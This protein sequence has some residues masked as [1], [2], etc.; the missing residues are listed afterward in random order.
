MATLKIYTISFLA[1]WG[2]AC[3]HAQPPSYSCKVEIE[4]KAKTKIKFPAGD[5]LFISFDDG[6]QNDTITI[7]AKYKN[8]I[9]GNLNA[10]NL[11][12]FAGIMKIPKNELKYPIR[13]FFDGQPVEVLKVKTRFS[14]V[15]LQFDR[16]NRK[17]IWRYHRYKFVYL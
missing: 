5:T 1:L 13:L 15:H 3:L 11:Y 8:F 12:G 4:K 17:F 7:K 14:S 10:E 2:F 6:F 9:S 16:A